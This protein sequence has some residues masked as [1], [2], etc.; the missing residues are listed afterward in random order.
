MRSIHQ[1]ALGE[2]PQFIPLSES[3]AFRALAMNTRSAG[4]LASHRGAAKMHL[5]LCS[6]VQRA[7]PI[8]RFQRPRD[9]SAVD[10]HARAILAR[11][12]R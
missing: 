1:L 11:L 7:L 10:D 12:R 9:A 5:R 2:G 3:D 6:A 8:E 4:L